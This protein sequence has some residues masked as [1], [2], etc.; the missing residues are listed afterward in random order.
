MGIM[1]NHMGYV[2]DANLQQRQCQGILE[3]R[4]KQSEQ[5]EM[6]QS[7]S[8]CS[9]LEDN[10]HPET[11]KTKGKE[12]RNWRPLARTS[13]NPALI[14]QLKAFRV[15]PGIELGSTERLP[16]VQHHVLQLQATQLAE[17]QS[18]LWLITSK[19]HY[20]VHPHAHEEPAAEIHHGAKKHTITASAD[21][22]LGNSSD[23]HFPVC[24]LLYLIQHST[25]MI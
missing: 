12:G 25:S 22:D 19:S 17:C 8:L 24:W 6:G 18:S 10:Q 16:A 1:S 4:G 2:M 15:G 20:C 3:Q 9:A 14:G 7:I 21:R 23:K 5:I 13:S 11:G